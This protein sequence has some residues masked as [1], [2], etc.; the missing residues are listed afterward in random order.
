MMTCREGI[1]TLL[2]GFLLFLQMKSVGDLPPASFLTPG[3][4]AAEPD[5]L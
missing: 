1:S 2:A 3:S 5:M 4:E